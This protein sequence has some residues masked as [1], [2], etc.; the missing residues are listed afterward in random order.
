MAEVPNQTDVPADHRVHDVSA[1]LDFSV[2]TKSYFIMDVAIAIA[3]LSIE[4]NEDGQLDVGGHFLAGY[5]QFRQLNDAE[6]QC[7]KGLVCSRLCQSLVFGA[8]SYSQQP[9]NEYLLTTAKQGWPLLHKFWATDDQ[10]LLTRWRNI[11]ASYK[12]T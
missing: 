9:G 2:V 12:T 3:Y 4:C 10:E 1:L 6:W 11:I 7:L 5:T 8:H